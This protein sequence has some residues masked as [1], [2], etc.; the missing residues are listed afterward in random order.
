[1][2]DNKGTIEVTSGNFSTNVKNNFA[3][4]QFFAK[5]KGAQNLSSTL[6]SLAIFG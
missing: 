4:I 5:N 6:I 1:M 2:I 3:N